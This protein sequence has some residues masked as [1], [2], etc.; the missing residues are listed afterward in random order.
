MSRLSPMR[1]FFILAPLGMLY[2]AIFGRVVQL[3]ASPDPAVIGVSEEL[4]NTTELTAMRGPILDRNGKVLAYDRP[5]YQLYMDLAW[6]QRRYHPA[7]RDDDFTDDDVATEIATI[8]ERCQVPVAK[9]AEALLSQTVVHTVLRR[10]VDMFEAQALQGYL[11]NY[12]GTGLRLSPSLARVYPLGRTYGTL[13]GIVDGEG[14]KRE[15]VSGLE[16]KFDE[17][18][19]GTAGSKGSQMVTGAF[20]VNPAKGMRQPEQGNA[21]WTTLDADLGP[22]T[23]EVLARSM[24]LTN[25]KWCGA[26]VMDVNTGEILTLLGLPDF[27]PRDPWVDEDSKLDHSGQR[28]SFALAMENA[29]VPGSTFKPFVVGHAVDQGIVSRS[30]IFED[31]GVIYIPGRGAVKNAALVNPSP[32]NAEEC[33][34]HSS[35][36]VSIRIGQRIGTDRFPQMM[37][38]FGL[39][40]PVILGQRKS[41]RGQRISKKEWDRRKAKNWPLVSA[42]FGHQFMVNPIRYAACFSALVNGGRRIEPKL[43]VSGLEATPELA[44]YRDQLSVG[45]ENPIQESTSDFLVTAMEKMVARRIGKPLPEIEGVRWGGKSGT[46]R[47]ETNEDLNTCTFAAFGPIPDPQIL[48]FVVVQWPQVEGKISGTKYAGPVAGEI[49]EHALR[50]RGLLPNTGASRLDSASSNANLNPRLKEAR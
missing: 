2:L 46:A 11:R 7:N 38:R 37:D 15:G 25:A 50:T 8:A 30:E 22:A 42:S 35:N 47:L 39:W 13:L 6:A 43:L 16:Y 44:A 48:V 32:K 9:M 23:R 1:P 27:D 10:N 21:L 29:V 24:E 17:Q 12:R 19:Q 4:H 41:P 45:V 49:L 18:L 14:D 36:V 28:S 33:L 3:H 40:D 5:V 26:V 20:G 34:V 31:G